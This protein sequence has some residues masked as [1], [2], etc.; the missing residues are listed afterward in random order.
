MSSSFLSVFLALNLVFLLGTAM[1]FRL[2]HAS[3]N[4][5]ERRFEHLSAQELICEVQWQYSLRSNLLLF[6]CTAVAYLLWIGETEF[7]LTLFGGIS[8]VNVVTDILYNY[9]EVRLFE[10]AKSGHRMA[11]IVIWIVATVYFLILK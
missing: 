9:N 11:A 7:V 4:A 5:V 1:W 3:P 2:D 10:T 6:G 8:I